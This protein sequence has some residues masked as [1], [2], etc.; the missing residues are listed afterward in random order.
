MDPYLESHWG[1]VHASVAVSIRNQL[2]RQLPSDLVARLEETL[3][4]DVE[5]PIEVTFPST[6]PKKKYRPDVRIEKSPVPSAIRP[7]AGMAVLAKP[8][9][10]RWEVVPRVQRSVRILAWRNENRLVTAIE[11]LSPGNKVG[12]KGRKEYRKKQRDLIAAG[13]NLVELDLTRTGRPVFAVPH[14]RIP[15][16]YLTGYRACVTRHP[17][18][19]SAELYRFPLREHLPVIAIPLRRTDADI[20]LDLQAL[21]DTSYEAGRYDTIDYEKEPLPPLDPADADWADALLRK[22]GLRGRKNGRTKKK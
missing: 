10:V 2:Q 1:D 12:G 6:E 4:V 9:H 7:K 22:A 17:R 15:A 21:V 19:G 8:L 18:H 16:G 3:T 14:D 11:L 5:T 20:G 13:A